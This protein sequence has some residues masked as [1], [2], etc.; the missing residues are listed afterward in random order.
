MTPIRLEIPLP[1]R[2]SLPQPDSPH[3][4]IRVFPPTEIR[5]NAHYS[6]VLYPNGKTT[7]TMTLDGLSNKVEGEDVIQCWKLKKASWRLEETIRSVAKACPRHCSVS[8][9]QSDEPRNEVMRTETRILGEKIIPKCWKEE[10]SASGGSA[11]L[12]F[13]FSLQGPRPH[14]HNSA[15]TPTRHACDI[16]TSTSPLPGCEVTVSHALMV[17]F[18]VSKARAATAQPDVVTETGTGRILRMRFK[19][20]LSEAGT[21]VAWDDEAPPLYGDVPPSPPGY[22]GSGSGSDDDHD[23]GEPEDVISVRGS[24]EGDAPAE[25]AIHAARNSADVQ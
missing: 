2:R 21:G 8:L 1:V 7:M 19:V 11:D 12:E 22:G 23:D 17:E 6:Q 13:D 25:E 18:V 20:Y 4:S 15:M 9:R 16:S 5:A 14:P 3:H 10:Y 24:E